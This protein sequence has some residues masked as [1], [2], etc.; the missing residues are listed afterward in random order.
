M[1]VHDLETMR[2]IR[3]A[4]DR[5]DTSIM[6]Y[7]EGWTGGDC[8]LSS[9]RQALKSNISK[10][11]GVGAFSDDIRDSVKGNVFDFYDRGFIN[12]GMGLEENIR[13]GVVAATSHNQI[14]NMKS[15]AA[16]P[17]QSIN[18]V[19]CHDN[20]TF[21]DKLSISN[22]EDS[23]E[24]RE[25]MNRLGSAIIFMSQGVPFIQAGEEILRSKPSETSMTGFEENSYC[26]PDSVNSIKWNEKTK[27]LDTYKYYRGLIEFRK[28]HSALRM[29][30]ADEIR[31]NLVFMNELDKNVVA[32]TIS[33]EAVCDISK[34]I[35]VVFNANRQAVDIKLPCG[36]WN[37]CVNDTAAGITPLKTA[38]GTVTVP[39]V[40][41]MA[42]VQD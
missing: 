13:F 36:K 8:A 5:I 37:I 7:G 30:S 22:A 28:A 29:T 9:A 35:L 15:W 14:L 23:A 42:L 31:N 12:G 4:L 2:A 18:Y 41:A 25:R 27:A 16:A 1:A 21:W 20:L 32:F 10:V 34:K 11:P 24:L 39:Y 26:S 33:G 38:E 40:S 19:S 6:V 3:E 17:G